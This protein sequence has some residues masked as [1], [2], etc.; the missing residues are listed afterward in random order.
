MAETLKVLG[1][2]VP[3]ATTLTALYTV[4]GSV[5]AVISSIIICNQNP[6]TTIKFRISLAKSNAVDTPA[7]YIYYDLPLIAN[8][9]FIATVGI[10]LAATDVVRVQS[11]TAN[12]SFN[13]LGVEV[14]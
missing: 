14:A 6:A 2:V 3:T 12:V 9:T 4:P 5:S 11:D 7:Q 8:D 13:L 10:S 1:Q